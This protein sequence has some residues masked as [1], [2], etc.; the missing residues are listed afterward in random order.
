MLVVG[1]EFA[2]NFAWGCFSHP[3]PGAPQPPVRGLWFYDLTTPTPEVLGHVEGPPVTPQAPDE[4]PPTERPPRLRV[5]LREA[6]GAV[7]P[8]ANQ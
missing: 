6:G 1:D 4:G 3:V 2:D 8:I 5:L 7:G